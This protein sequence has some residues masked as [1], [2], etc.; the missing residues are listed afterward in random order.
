M[1]K[2][3]NGLLF[4]NIVVVKRILFNL[5][6]FHIFTPDSFR[7]PH[8]HIDASSR[9]PA[10]IVPLTLLQ[11]GIARSFSGIALLQ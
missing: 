1:W 2:C 8:F 3:E 6:H 11:G 9:D 7:V 5:N 10:S 4:E